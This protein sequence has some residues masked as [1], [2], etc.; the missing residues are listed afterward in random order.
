MVYG[1]ASWS[2]LPISTYGQVIPNGDELDFDGV[3][4]T[5]IEQDLNIKSSEEFV[6]ELIFELEIELETE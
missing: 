2:E 1:A 5:S 4:K 6:S 3:I